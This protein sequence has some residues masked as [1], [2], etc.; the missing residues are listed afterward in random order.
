M[1]LR[2]A[3]DP[4]RDQVSHPR[5]SLL[6]P[7]PKAGCFGA[8]GLSGGRGCRRPASYASTP[9]GGTCSDGAMTRPPADGFVSAA[10]VRLRKRVHQP[11]RAQ[12]AAAEDP[13]RRAGQVKLD[14]RAMPDPTV[15]ARMTASLLSEAI[16]PAVL[17]ARAWSNPAN[18]RRGVISATS[19]AIM[20]IHSK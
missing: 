1:R 3:P 15:D 18:W 8:A 4:G 17:R 16:S 9:Q 13:C 10:T 6:G 14:G 7:S 20:I 2:P 5:P 12:I 19:C 11:G